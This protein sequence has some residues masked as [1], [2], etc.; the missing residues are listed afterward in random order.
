MKQVKNKY[1]KNLINN[2]K[3]IYIMKQVFNYLK[4]KPK[5]GIIKYNKKIQT[6]LNID[7][8]DYKTFNKIE[9]E[10]FPIYEINYDEDE[11]FEDEEF[12]SEYGFINFEK[13]MGSYYH[14]YFKEEAIKNIEYEDEFG[15][16]FLDEDSNIKKIKIIID[17]EV[18]S[19]RN[20]F[21][22][23]IC[24]EKINFIKFNTN[25]I[26]NM[27]S[28]FYFCTSLKE[29]NLNN[30]NTNNVK[31]M[32]NM[33]RYCSSL[34]KL[35]LNNFNTNNVIDMSCMFYNCSSLKQLNL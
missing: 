20:L 34:E 12:E 15:R 2:I 24:I 6:K 28:M 29:I 17:E 22:A 13:N 4:E 21:G 19:L 10:I 18:K 1:I 26:I 7:I 5:L 31:N 16:V 25:N 33:F 23:C 8:N 14:I 32:K 27:E 11:K 9:I 30:F 35:N 3:S